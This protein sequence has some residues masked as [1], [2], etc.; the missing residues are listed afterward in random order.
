MTQD[1]CRRSTQRHVKENTTSTLDTLRCG[2]DCSAN[3]QPLHIQ[4]RKLEQRQ[5]KI[6][7]IRRTS[8]TVKVYRLQLQYGS[9]KLQV[10][11]SNTRSWRPFQNTTQQLT[12]KE[13]PEPTQLCVLGEKKT[14]KVTCIVF[15]HVQILVR[16]ARQCL[17]ERLGLRTTLGNISQ[18]ARR[19]R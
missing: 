9:W 7:S 6:Y 11:T 15:C 4:Q 17:G 3:R 14:Q 19:I 10:I 5:I 1:K 12:E 16:A 8:S 18:A 13:E 2:T